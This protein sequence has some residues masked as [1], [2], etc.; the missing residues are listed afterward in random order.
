[1]TFP[2]NNPHHGR[3]YFTKEIVQKLFENPS[4]RLKSDIKVIKVGKLHS[5]AS[6]FYGSVRKL[7]KPVEKE[8]DCFD[9]MICLTMMQNPKKIYNLYKLGLILLC[10]I[11]GGSYYADGS[12][13][14]VLIYATKV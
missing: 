1:M 5:L 4:L 10:K 8:V 7:L 6:L 12:G 11:S 13:N 14:R 2:I 3:N 9:D